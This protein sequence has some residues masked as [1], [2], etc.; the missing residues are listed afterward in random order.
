MPQEP[1][2]IEVAYASFSTG[3]IDRL[4]MGRKEYGDRSFSKDPLE[5]LR[6]IDEELMDV[7]GWAF[8]LH[9]RIES[10]REALNERLR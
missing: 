1:L 8:I 5:L 7:C 10:I 9:T 4:S 6:E 2:D 3:V